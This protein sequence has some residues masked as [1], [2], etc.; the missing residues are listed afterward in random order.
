M[1]FAAKDLRAYGGSNAVTDCGKRRAER[2]E[3]RVSHPELRLTGLGAESRS[4]ADHPVVG[5]C[6]SERQLLLHADH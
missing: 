6:T 2:F 4:S 3:T 5:C 1:L